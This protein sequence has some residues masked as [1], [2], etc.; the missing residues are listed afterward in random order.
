M[1]ILI[2]AILVLVGLPAY[3]GQQEKSKVSGARQQ[4]ATAY[5]A[6]RYETLS[7]DLSSIGYYP[8]HAE[9]ESKMES[10]EP[11]LGDVKRVANPAGVSGPGVHIIESTTTPTH[12]S[13]GVAVDG[14]PTRRIFLDHDLTVGKLVYTG[15][16]G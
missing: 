5:K 10:T 9:L 4:L 15:F 7:D 2:I 12:L 3:L 11:S 16:E 6:A 1:V 13:L 14:D 8:A